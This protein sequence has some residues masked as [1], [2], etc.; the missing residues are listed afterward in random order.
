MRRYA[1]TKLEQALCVFMTVWHDYSGVIYMTTY[2]N[3]CHVEWKG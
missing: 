1:L 2:L 3:P